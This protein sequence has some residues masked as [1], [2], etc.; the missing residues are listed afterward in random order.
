MFENH[1]QNAKKDPSRLDNGSFLAVPLTAPWNSHTENGIKHII[2]LS[3]QCKLFE[4]INLKPYLTY[5]EGRYW[6]KKSTKGP[7]QVPG[8]NRAYAWH[9]GTE[10]AT[11]LY[12]THYFKEATL[13]EGF[14]IKMEPSVSFPYTPDFSKKYFREV[15]NNKGAKEKKY[16]FE[17]L[18][19]SIYLANRTTAILSCKL[20]NTV[21]LKVKTAKDP[22][23][24]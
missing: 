13:V 20:H 21:E 16:A 19:P 14:R 17:G 10:L 2:P 12:H 11:I 24:K 23:K 1:F 15:E 7:I 8:C 9:F 18:R 22:E 4:Y 5:N 3:M 6:L